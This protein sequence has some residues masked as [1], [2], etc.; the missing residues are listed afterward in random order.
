MFD[1]SGY[2]NICFKIWTSLSA[3]YKQFLPVWRTPKSSMAFSLPSATP[4]PPVCATLGRVKSV[5]AGK[6]MIGVAVNLFE[7][8]HWTLSSTLIRAESL[9]RCW[10]HYLNWEQ[11]PIE[12]SRQ[13]MQLMSNVWLEIVSLFYCDFVKQSLDLDFDVMK[14]LVTKPSD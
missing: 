6:P 14:L 1:H 7:S 13:Q 10:A 11:S 2:K 5:E 3:I 12:N 8:T 9:I 4:F